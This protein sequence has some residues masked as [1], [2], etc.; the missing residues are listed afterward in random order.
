[1]LRLVTLLAVALSLAGC[2]S[3]EA[4]KEM[5]EQRKA[6]IE[7]AKIPA[8]QLSPE[9]M[10]KIQAL[11]PRGEVVWLRAGRRKDGK[12]FVCHVSRGKTLFGGTS[13]GLW[14]GTFEADGGYQ[15]A[16]AYLVSPQA[17]VQDCN[18]HGYEPPITI[19]TTYT[20]VR[21]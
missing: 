12:I 16:P 20:T 21:Y 15:R 3:R 1:V 17:V 4:L 19:R 9:Q 5:E 14:S 7:A 18:N 11:S 13:V 8:I 10:A 6:R 2:V